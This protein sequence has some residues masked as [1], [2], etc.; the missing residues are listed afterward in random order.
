[1]CKWQQTGVSV[2]FIFGDGLGG[3]RTEMSLPCNLEY[4]LHTTFGL[5]PLPWWD[6]ATRWIRQ[7]TE[8]N[9]CAECASGSYA[10]R[11]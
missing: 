6:G 2:G 7:N 11:T 10:R 9:A 4:T 3:V 1:M 5:P 8:K